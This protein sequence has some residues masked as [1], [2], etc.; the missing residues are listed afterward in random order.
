MGGRSREPA[1]RAGLR[2]RGSECAL[3]DELVAAIRRGES[4]SLVLRGEAGIGKTA[5]LEYLIASAPDATIVRTVGVQSDMELPYAALHQLCGPLLD[6][7]EALP[8][9]QR[10]AMEIAFG[11]T[12][13]DAPDR[14]LV[15]LAV[16]SLFSEVAEQR[17]LLCVVDDAQWL[18]QA[19]ALTMA[20]VARRLLA[21]PVAIVFAA[22]EPGEELLHVSELVVGGLRNRDARA[23]LSSAVPFKLDERVRDRIIAETRGNP[24]ALLELPRGLTARQLAGGFGLVE[25][26]G[27][28]GR[29]EE[30]FVRRVETLSDDARRL[31]L[32]AAAEPVGDPLLLLAACER[33]EI[34]VSAVDAETDGLLALGER[35][36]FRHPLVRSAVYRTATREQR[37]EVHLALAEATDGSVDP[38]RRAWHLATAAVG[39]DEPVAAALEQSAGRAQA[40]GGRAAAG[41]F[42]HR[43]VVRT[44]DPEQRTRRA[45]A[46]AQAS[47][48]AGMF[49][50][51]LELL[52]LAEASMPDELQAAHVELLR[53]QIA[54]A[55]RMGPTAPPLLL[56]AAQGFERLEPELARETYLDAWG[57]AFFAGRFATAGSLAEVSRSTTSASRSTRPLRASDLLLDGLSTLVT[58]GRAAAAPLLRRAIAT[59]ADN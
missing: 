21:E 18:D 53:G 45:L 49:E 38:D 31:L 43:S 55:S 50:G 13:G 6:R 15:G 51:A 34:A 19:S 29:I 28:A 48:H 20:F 44:S 2:G 24:L 40:R 30:S 35:V 57:A 1:G 41:A 14:F 7:L 58:E 27:L 4:Q 11:V 9:P 32:V 59:F 26:Q 17:P 23:L 8:A 56:K 36:I 5:L 42:L 47:L 22:R 25:A 39:P 54:F 3:L 52:A 12:A 16:L 10:R 37:R 46:A 33:L